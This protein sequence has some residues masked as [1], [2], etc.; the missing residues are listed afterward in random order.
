LPS[1]SSATHGTRNKQERG[2]KRA[3]QDSRDG[4]KG[5][6]KA[7]KKDKKSKA[8]KKKASQESTA[9]QDRLRLKNEHL[10][11][12]GYYSLITSATDDGQQRR[13]REEG[14]TFV[15]SISKYKALAVSSISSSLSSLLFTTDDQQLIMNPD[16]FLAFTLQVRA[17]VYARSSKNDANNDHRPRLPL[18]VHS[19]STDA[20][21]V[22]MLSLVD[23]STVGQT[24]VWRYL[25]SPDGSS[26]VRVAFFVGIRTDHEN[27]RNAY[28]KRY[29][30]EHIEEW[31]RECERIA[32]ALLQ[33]PKPS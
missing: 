12:S 21:T 27:A 25:R 28:Y 15:L 5:S 7:G 16:E 31:T 1:S 30:S 20:I 22:S 8:K 24:A 10:V 17:E 11:G 26:A 32:S 18:H 13:H 33:A 14:F 4:T 9:R 23:N 19:R 2:D 3:R 29:V 6:S